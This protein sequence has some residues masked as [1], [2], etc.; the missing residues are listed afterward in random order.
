MADEAPVRILHVCVNFGWYAFQGGDLGGWLAP[1]LHR[2]SNYTCRCDRPEKLTVLHCRLQRWSEPTLR[3]MLLCPAQLVVWILAVWA[4]N[5]TEELRGCTTSSL[6][7]SQIV[8]KDL[9]RVR[10][11]LGPD[12]LPPPHNFSPSTL[13]SPLSLTSHPPSSPTP[14]PHKGMWRSETVHQ[15]PGQCSPGVSSSYSQNWQH[16]RNWLQTAP[17]SYLYLYLHGDTAQGVLICPVSCKL[18]VSLYH[19]TVCHVIITSLCTTGWVLQHSTS[20]RGPVH[21]S[22]PPPNQWHI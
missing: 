20:C 5:F 9:F 8:W 4:L 18:S 16:I 2:E 6:T 3:A 22:P 15:H 1:S 19:C 10:W 11:V 13:I 7:T 21:P 17:E 14:S 12:T